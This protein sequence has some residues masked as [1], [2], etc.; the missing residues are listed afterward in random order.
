MTTSDTIAKEQGTVP[1]VRQRRRRGVSKDKTVNRLISLGVAVVLVVTCEILV[2]AGV[3]SRLVLPAPTDVVA[4]L[5]RGVQS[6][7]YPTHILSTLSSALTGFAIVVVLAVLIAGLLAMYARLEEI[8]YP[9]I[10]AFQTLPKIAIAPLVIIWVGFGDPS[11]IVIVAISCFFPVFVNV[12]EGLRIRDKERAELMQ[13]IGANRWQTFRYVRLPGSLPFFFT[14]L[15]LGII[16][17]LIGTIVAEFVGSRSG[18]GVLLLQAKAMFD[19]PSMFAVLLILMVLGIVLNR[20]V[21]FL[22]RRLVF[23]A[24]EQ[25]NA[26]G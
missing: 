25:S 26:V 22:E 21:K 13:A 14:G 5:V 6:G 11:K 3:V 8:A 19:V 2:G 24:R 9:F 20:S 18:L 17:A 12:L 10:V 4:A 1:P 23:W 7:V 15:H 16:F